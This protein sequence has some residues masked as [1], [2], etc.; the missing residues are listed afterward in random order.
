MVLPANTGRAVSR[1]TGQT[2]SFQFDADTGNAARITSLDADG[3]SVG[4]S[5]DVNT[6]GQNY[7]WIAWNR[8][9]GLN[10]I[11]TYTGTGARWADRLHR[12]PARLRDR[13]A[14][15]TR[16][17]PAAHQ[18]MSSQAA[19]D[20]YPFAATGSLTD[21]ITAF[22]SV[23]VG[24]GANG[25][26]NTN[27]A[28]HSL[29]AFK[30]RPYA[31]RRLLRARHPDRHRQRRQLRATGQRRATTTEPTRSS[32]SR[33][34]NRNRRAFVRFTLPA[35]PSGCSVAYAKL[36]LYDSAPIA[37]R[38]INVHTR[39]TRPGSRGRRHH[40]LDQPAR[41]V[42][43]LQS[44]GPPRGW[45]SSGRDQRGEGPLHHQQRLPPLRRDG[46]RGSQPR[47]R[48]TAARGRQQPPPAAGHF[49]VIVALRTSAAH[50][51]RLGRCRLRDRPC[52]LAGGRP[53]LR[54]PGPHR[55]VGQHGAFD[56]HRRCGDR[57][58]DVA[59]GREG[60]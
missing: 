28:T 26:A 19:G 23:D 24:L 12:L 38:T 7:H 21:S 37:G 29:V 16:P 22:N 53:L 8:R 35:I 25:V 6:A 39:R 48:P 40:H 13:A 36:R 57:E 41:C 18:R 52:R 55:D 10:E 49:P 32:R 31:R 1:A 46:E 4:T 45:T 58:S 15:T 59:D 3:F 11:T 20:S 51:R 33:N 2:T 9:G 44:A 30:S 17:P 5:G 34:G 54:P 56:Q 47:P 27:G 14:R 43:H 60:G 50:C 42:R